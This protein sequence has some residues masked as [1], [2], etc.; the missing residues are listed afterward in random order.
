VAHTI[1]KLHKELGPRGLHPIAIAFDNGISGPKVTAFVQYFGVTFPVG[2]SSSQ[3]VDSY[4]GRSPAERLRVPQIVV[5][6]RKGVIR[7]QSRPTDETNLETGNYLRNLIDSLLKEGAPAGNEH[8]KAHERAFTAST[9]H[10]L[11]SN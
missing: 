9:I 7:A 2:Y 1:T 3:A 4:L 11:T 8:A 5:I 6:D 10:L